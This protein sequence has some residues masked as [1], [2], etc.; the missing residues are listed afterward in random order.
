MY[1]LVEG[2]DLAG[3]ST[4]SSRLC[5]RLG[6]AWSIRHNALLA[7]SPIQALADRL[8]K[9]G[10]LSVRVVG[11]LYHAALLAE[12]EVFQRPA[13]NVIQDSTIVLR[14]LAY[15]TANGTDGLPGL[16]E[17]A[18]TSHPKFDAAFVCVANRESRLA[19]LKKRR[20][21]NLSA[22]DFL[23]R[24]GYGLFQR[25]EAILIEAA[26][27]HFGATVLDTSCLEDPAASDRLVDE[28]VR[29]LDAV[30]ARDAK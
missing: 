24:D 5:E 12:L 30:R 9:E 8:R 6:P 13:G 10:K 3:K 16:F 28:V 21:E 17:A 20:K 14:S 29:H 19:R 18:L 1:I 25:S 11:F 23:V 26:R 27:R 7:D 4:L 15:H 2:L 22:E